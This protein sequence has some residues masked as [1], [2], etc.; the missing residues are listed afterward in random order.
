MRYTGNGTAMTL[1]YMNA[2]GEWQTVYNYDEDASTGSWVNDAY[3]IV[4]LGTS[5]QTVTAIFKAD[6]VA[7]TT[8]LTQLATPQ[9]VTADGTNVSWDEVENATSYEVIEGGNNVLGTVKT[10][11]TLS[12]RNNEGL[13]SLKYKKDGIVTSSDYDGTLN[14]TP[15]PTNIEGIKS[16]ITFGAF[17]NGDTMPISE[18]YNMVNCTAEQVSAQVAKLILTGNASATLNPVD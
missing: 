7:N 14:Y 12:V 6:F 18:I 4:D 3:K 13:V 9:N 2:D 11:F 16:Y 8:K 17:G 5:A 15:T 1:Q 10:Q